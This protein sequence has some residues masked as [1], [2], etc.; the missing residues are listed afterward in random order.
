MSL[1]GNP[2]TPWKE[3]KPDQMPTLYTP[4]N[5]CEIVKEKRFVVLLRVWEAKAESHENFAYCV[6]Q[7]ARLN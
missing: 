1:E 6:V 4:V 2:F 5:T 3:W 7:L